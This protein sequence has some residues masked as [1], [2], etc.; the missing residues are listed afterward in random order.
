MDTWLKKV[1]GDTNI[2]YLDYILGEKPTSIE[3]TTVEKELKNKPF[4]KLP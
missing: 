2:S 4:K 1:F 3:T